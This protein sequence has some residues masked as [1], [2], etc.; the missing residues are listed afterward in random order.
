[1]W[2][3][4]GDGGSGEAISIVHTLAFIY[5]INA[6]T[7]VEYRSILIWHMGLRGDI[8]VGSNSHSFA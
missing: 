5:V 1:M 2:V 8:G 3:G 6:I 7:H 4:D